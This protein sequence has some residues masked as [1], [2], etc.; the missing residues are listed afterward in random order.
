VRLLTL[1]ALLLAAPAAAEPLT[2][3]FAAELGGKPFACGQDYAGLGATGT[4]A[5]PAD[6]RLF[7]T[8]VALIGADGKEVPVP[9]TDDGTWQSKGVAMLDFEDGSGACTNGN[10]FMNDKLTVDAPKGDW[11]GLA[12]TMASV[13]CKS[14][15]VTY[16]LS[17]RR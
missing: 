11:T 3:P 17:K 8:D 7:V 14:F 16:A 5:T 13:A 2:I 12:F 9:L 10:A 15:L 4:Q 1:F 6:F